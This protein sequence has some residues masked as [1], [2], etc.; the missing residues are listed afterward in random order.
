MNPIRT[1]LGN[2]SVAASLYLLLQI[3]NVDYQDVKTQWRF[4][5]FSFLYWNFSIRRT[6]SVVWASFCK[7]E[8]IL[9]IFGFRRKRSLETEVD[10]LNSS[11]A[12]LQRD[13]R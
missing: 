1:V 11:K 4:V 9:F 7:V 6:E 10:K 5:L 8:I 13:I 2:A 12:E 3:V